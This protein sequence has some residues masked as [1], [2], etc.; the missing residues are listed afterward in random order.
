VLVVDEIW[1]KFVFIF[2]EVF[3]D[4]VFGDIEDFWVK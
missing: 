2:W 4:V 3:E 1:L